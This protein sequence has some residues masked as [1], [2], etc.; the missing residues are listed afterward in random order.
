MGTP[1]FTFTT[2]ED[3]TIAITGYTGAGG[4]VTIPGT[5][6]GLPVTSIG[7]DAFAENAT[8]TSVTIPDGV[9]LIE[10]GAFWYCTNL[11][12]VMIPGTVTKIGDGAFETCP[13]LTGV[14]FLGNA[15]HHNVS[16]FSGDNNATI[17]YLPGTTGWSPIYA[18]RPTALWS[19]PYPLILT[20]PSFG[21]Q[22]NGFGFIISWAT[23]LPVMVE[24]RTDLAIASW[25]PVATNILTNGSSY[26][27]DPTWTNH[28]ARLY[29]LRSP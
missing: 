1:Q 7:I 24:A 14:Y 26:F 19:L 22:T 18:G 2:N 4:A 29:R 27:S 25:S 6:R 21:I 12:S 28:P 23:N 16:V 11:T 13:S 3:N 17:Y 8:L 20:R 5:I 10:N 15:S 9:T